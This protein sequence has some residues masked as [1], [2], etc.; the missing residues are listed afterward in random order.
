MVVVVVAVVVA[1]A[2]AVAAQPATDPALAD[3]HTL[4]RRHA[5]IQPRPSN[6]S[7]TPVPVPVPSPDPVTRHPH[8]TSPPRAGA[9]GTHFFSELHAYP[10]THS[11]VEAHSDRHAFASVQ[12]KGAQSRVVVPSVLTRV[13]SPSH[14]VALRGTQSPP[15]HWNCGLQSASVTQLVLQASGPQANF[16]HWV[17]VGSPQAPLPPQWAR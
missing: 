17:V 16:T 9:I 2:V 10:R 11:A 5:R 15:S 13:W 6:P 8:P 4:R 3:V 7:P 12:R 1:V 14:R